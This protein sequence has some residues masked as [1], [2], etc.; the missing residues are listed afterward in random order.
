MAPD[1]ESAT[2]VVQDR[3]DFLMPHP[4]LA[5]WG[6]VLVFFGTFGTFGV[7][8]GFNA[9]CIFVEMVFENTFYPEPSTVRFVSIMVWTISSTAIAVYPFASAFST[10]PVLPFYSQNHATDKVQQPLQK[11]SAYSSRAW[12]CT[13]AAVL[14][15]YVVCVVLS[16]AAY[17]VVYC[18]VSDTHE[19][20]A[21]R[22][23]ALVVF[24]LYVALAAPI[25]AMRATCA[26]RSPRT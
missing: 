25:A 1:I 20:G 10:F 16:L 6:M 17:T 24:A 23:L 8:A 2:A 22:F 11:K 4:V 3:S 9:M 13:A 14:A 19:F 7:V 5:A 26:D 15:A 12:W 21:P 18:A